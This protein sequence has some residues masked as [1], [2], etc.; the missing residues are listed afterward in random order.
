MSDIDDTAVLAALERAVDDML[1][2]ARKGLFGATEHLK[3]VSSAQ[4]PHRDGELEGNAEA[5]VDN[6]ALVGEVVFPDAYA[7]RQHEEPSYEHKP[8]RRDHYLSAAMVDEQDAM[9]DYIADSI[10]REAGL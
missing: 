1:K 7:A 4:A 10:R 9:A 8:G 5:H 2:G 6:D 3:Q